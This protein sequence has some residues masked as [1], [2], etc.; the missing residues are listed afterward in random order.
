M[1]ANTVRYRLHN[2]EALKEELIELEENL[3][4]YRVMDIE[5][6]IFPTSQDS[7][8]GSQHYKHS[9]NSTTE[10]IA[11]PRLEHIRQLENRIFQLRTILTAINAVIRKYDHESLEWNVLNL[12]YF[13]KEHGNTRPWMRVANILKYNEVYVRE[14]DTNIIKQITKYIRNYY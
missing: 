5:D 14:V 1:K 10:N 11:I 9:T 7:N 12:R 13:T 4:R 2:F 8:T 3:N 6:F